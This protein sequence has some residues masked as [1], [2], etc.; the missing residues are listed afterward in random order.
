MEPLNV[1]GHATMS[2]AMK[3]A[4]N[5]HRYLCSLILLHLGRY[6]KQM[7]GKLQSAGFR[8]VEMKYIDPVGGLGWYLNSKFYKPASRSQFKIKG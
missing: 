3:D 8:V 2:S 5:Y 7:L 4:H 1:T 6:T